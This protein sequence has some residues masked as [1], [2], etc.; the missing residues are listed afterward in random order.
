VLV[1]AGS[2]D[3]HTTL[4]ESQELFDAAAVPQI[5]V[6]RRGCASP[7]FPRIRSA[8]YDAHVV[9][10][11]IESLAVGGSSKSPDVSP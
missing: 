7:G 6:D 4:T 10:F 2:K 3:E 8:G 5:T 1:V 11:L 9:E